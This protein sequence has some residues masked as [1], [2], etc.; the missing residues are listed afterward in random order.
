MPPAVVTL[1]AGA[2]TVAVRK[3]T[4]AMPFARGGQTGL[5]SLAEGTGPPTQSPWRPNRVPPC[6][7][8]VPRWQIS[9]VG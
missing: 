4:A 3:G 7:S 1:V 2:V 9:A 8:P 6:R 5:R